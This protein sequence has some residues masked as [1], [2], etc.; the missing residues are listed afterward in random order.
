MT[1]EQKQKGAAFIRSRY[2]ALF[3]VALCGMISAS[4]KEVTQTT[5][6]NRAPIG[7]K[8]DDFIQADETLDIANSQLAFDSAENESADKSD[9]V[10]GG[11]V[12]RLADRPEKDAPIAAI[13]ASV[14]DIAESVIDSETRLA[15]ECEMRFAADVS[16][17]PLRLMPAPFFLS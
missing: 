7:R 5:V 9:Y 2:A 8:A 17:L 13:V 3:G 1:N 16:A 10:V 15:Y 4:K 14:A 12:F 11:T 6:A